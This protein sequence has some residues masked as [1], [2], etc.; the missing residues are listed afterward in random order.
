MRRTGQAL[1]ILGGTAAV[2]IGIIGAFLPILPTTPFFLLAAFLFA[3]SSERLHRRVLGNRYL[4][5]YL[6]RYYERRAMSRRH[7]AITLTLLWLVLALSAALA[8]D[9][10]W[11]RAVLSA[12]GIG[13]TAHILSLSDERDRPPR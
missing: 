1:M 5:D 7:K 6:T 3:R 13:V 9:G 4:G 12:V 2:G 8:A 10:W 11:L